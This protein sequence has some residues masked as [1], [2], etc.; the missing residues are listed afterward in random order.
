MGQIN[1]PWFGPHCRHSALLIVTRFW[2]I[3]CEFSPLSVAK[4]RDF[5]RGARVH[6]MQSA[7][8]STEGGCIDRE[9]FTSEG[10]SFADIILTARNGQILARP[11]S[12]FVPQDEPSF[13]GE[14]WF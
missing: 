13:A 5:P 10:G 7:A 12:P 6:R 3:M 14:H 11:Q 9:Q 2:T 8:S 1:D 4:G